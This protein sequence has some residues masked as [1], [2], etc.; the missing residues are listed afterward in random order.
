MAGEVT[1][2][3]PDLIHLD[4]MSVEELKREIYRLR[5]IITEKG[6]VVKRLEGKLERYELAQQERTAMKIAESVERI[7]VS[8]GLRRLG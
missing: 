6:L 8:K 7:L 1:D 3:K 5:R 4:R 2:T